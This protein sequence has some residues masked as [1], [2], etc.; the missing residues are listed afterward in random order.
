MSQK[1][2]LYAFIIGGVALLL[3]ATIAY[4]NRNNKAMVGG[5]DNINQEEEVRDIV[6]DLSTEEEV[7]PEATGAGVLGAEVS[8][9]TD[10]K[11]VVSN[12]EK[13]QY[14]LFYGETCPHC[15]VVMDWMDETGIDS[16]LDITRKEVYNN[17]Q[18]SEQMKLAAQNC[19]IDRIG[20]PFLYDASQ[21]ECVVGS[22]PIIDHL[23]A[24][25][26]L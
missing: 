5:G 14:V 1:K 24:K 25:L 2:Q 3:I 9:E 13:Q 23:T 10:T 22:T 18:F 21:K 12:Q 15:H 19:G 16:R 6:Q 17:Q 11:P 8:K 7:T 4:G 20:V 26:G